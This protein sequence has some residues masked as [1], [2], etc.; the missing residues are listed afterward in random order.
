M[1]D[2]RTRRSV[3]RG[4]AAAGVAPMI[5]S[6]TASG[7]AAAASGDQLASSPSSVW[8]WTERIAGQRRTLNDVVRMDDGT[9]VGVGFATDDDDRQHSM[10]R[11]FDT[12]DRTV[13]EW[14]D[15]RDDHDAL[16]GGARTDSGA[17][18]FC[19]GS[20]SRGS[21]LMDTMVGRVA[22]DGTVET[23]VVEG[24]SGTNDAAHAITVGP[25]GNYVAAGGTHYL[26]GA[27]GG[28]VGRLVSVDPDGQTRWTATYETDYAGEYYDVITTSRGTLAFVGQR[29]ADDG[30]GHLWLGEV[31]PQGE[32]VWSETYGG[33]GD[34][35]GYSLTEAD[36]GGLVFCG[37]TTLPGRDDPTAWVGTVD[38]GGSLRWEETYGST[39][40]DVPVAVQRA[41]DGGYVVAGWTAG[42]TD[43]AGWLFELDDTGRL[44]WE[45]TYGD[46]G[47]DRVNGL[48]RAP[49]NGYVL[50]GVTSG[51]AGVPAAWSVGV[52]VGQRVG[53]L[54][55]NIDDRSF[56]RVF[57]DIV[58]D[59]WS[60]SALAETPAEELLDARADGRLDAATT[61]TAF[62]RM[63]L[64]YE[65]TRDFLEL[66]SPH[67]PYNFARSI[68][69]YILS[70]VIDLIM[71]GLA[72]GEK[73]TQVAPDRLTRSVDSFGSSLGVSD[74]NSPL[75]VD[76]F[77]DLVDYVLNKVLYDQSGDARSG[78]LARISTSAEDIF[79]DLWE[80]APDDLENAGGTLLD[81]KEQA[82]DALI[83]VI[84]MLIQAGYE[85]GALDLSTSLASPTAFTDPGALPDPVDDPASVTQV[86]ATMNGTWRGLV[87]L[88][89]EITETALDSGFDGTTAA[90]RT[91][92]DE[93]YVSVRDGVENCDAW[94]SL[95][96]DDL[97]S[98]GVVE[99]LVGALGAIKDIWQADGIVDRLF[100]T[101][102]GIIDVVQAILGIITKKVGLIA[103][104]SA[105]FVGGDILAT[106]ARA[107]EAV[108]DSAIDGRSEADFTS[109]YTE[110]PSPDETIPAY[111]EF[112]GV[113]D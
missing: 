66:G 57:P 33:P 105:A 94:L 107:N 95:V 35:L 19:G 10:L 44:Q 110:V 83:G 38:E 65:A 81:L 60:A 36:D 102:D 8:E 5:L 62:D 77:G 7:A 40:S 101:L 14:T 43:E 73:L 51:D 76:F 2:E 92:K 61:E 37:T 52:G 4:V 86:V 41:D 42:G 72:L 23:V 11:K 108:I 69:E 58:T 28:G 111:D 17:V 32:L 82:M 71:E 80:M 99:N 112:R 30:S 9:F 106:A 109:L 55:A 104:G 90:A 54:A 20:F 100:A 3:L 75:S 74:A 84:A 103:S 27:D 6:T 113:I 79:D 68:A 98:F 88:N 16:L 59:R 34:R 50:A 97:L 1:T 25:D 56:V 78:I 13:W 24:A 47:A 89:D 91:A 85:S 18:A 48:E 67:G 45:Q 22:S 53:S 31:D 93:T 64:G 15:D 96:V 63:A 29:A 46:S 21:S 70:V 87:R 49:I 26:G 12:T 39:D